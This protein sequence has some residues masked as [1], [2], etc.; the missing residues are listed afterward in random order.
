M[1]DYRVYLKEILIP[2]DV[3]QARIAELGVEISGIIKKASIYS[4]F[5]FYGEL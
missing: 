1:E 2:E 5:V 3:L 4:W